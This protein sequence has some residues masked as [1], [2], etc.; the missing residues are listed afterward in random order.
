TTTPKNGADGATFVAAL[1]V[2]HLNI[3]CEFAPYNYRADRQP[4]SVWYVYDDGSTKSA[5][6]NVIVIPG[7][8]VKAT[9]DNGASKYRVCYSSPKSFKDRFGHDAAIDVRDGNPTDFFGVTW[10]TG[11][12]PDCAKKNP[13][14]PC[15]VSWVGQGPARVGT[16]LTPPGDPGYR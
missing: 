9:P 14:P 15:V 5:K 3:D 6:T 12:L 7:N 13:V 11:L 8:V 4:N 1:N 2:P 16:F 10:Y